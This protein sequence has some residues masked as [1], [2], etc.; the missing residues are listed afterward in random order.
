M[1]KLLSNIKEIVT[2]LS[3]VSAIGFGYLNQKNKQRADDV[4]NNLYKKEVQWT[5]EK[6]ELVTETTEL[7]F[8]VED[9]KNAAAKDSTQL[10]ATE[11]MLNKAANRIKELESNINHVVSYNNLRMEAVHEDLKTKATI[12]DCKLDSIAPITTEH[13]KVEF[14]VLEDNEIIAKAT[15]N[16]EVDV[17]VDR[18]RRK[19]TR[20]GNKRFFLARWVKPV[21]D[22]PKAK[23][24]S[25]VTIN[26]DNRK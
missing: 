3:I 7:R 5:T 17:V 22:D 8:T 18:E 23:I 2:I 24:L 26:F 13:L 12:T 11:K 20:K 25:N 6:G 1:I 19:E 9:L 15:Y 21:C 14:E 16:A 4:S 10:S